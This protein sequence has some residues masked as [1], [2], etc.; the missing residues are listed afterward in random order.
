LE[1]RLGDVL[2]VPLAD[3]DRPDLVAIRAAWRAER[4]RL[5]GASDPRAWEEAIRGWSAVQWPRWALYAELRRV[6]ALVR[7]GADEARLTA[8]LRDVHARA[9]ALGSILVLAEVNQLAQRAGATSS[10]PRPP[11]VPDGPGGSDLDRLTRREREVLD[12]VAA[13]ATNR[14]VADRLFISEK[15]ASVHVSRILTKL[16]VTNRQEAGAVARRALRSRRGSAE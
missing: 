1:R 6:E 14:Q 5:D 11:L 7:E 8:A 12:L 9:E 16:G 13:G 10:A 3:A 4:T 15:T 2:A